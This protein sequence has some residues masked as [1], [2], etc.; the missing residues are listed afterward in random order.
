MNANQQRRVVVT[1]LGVVSPMGND[2]ETCWQ[3]ILAGKSG[4]KLIDT[5]DVT[6]F[7]AKIAGLVR[8]FEPQLYGISPKDARKMDIFVQYGIA[9][10]V[11]AV[12]DA[13][14]SAHPDNAARIGVSIG[15]GIGGLA[16][17]EK[18]HD[19]YRDSGPR[20]ISPF[21][22]PGAI[23]NMSAGYFSIM[24]GYKGPNLAFATACTTGAHS[25]GMAAR[26]IAYGDADIMIAGG[27]EKAS[28]PLGLGGFASARALSTRNEAP[29]Q[30]S[31]PWDV[32]RDGF[33]LGDGASVLV[34]E[35]Y[36]CAKK[37]GAKIYA[38]LVGF[39]MS[40][41][42]FHITSYSE[43]GLGE[44]AA[45][46]AALSDARLAPEAIDY[47]NAHGTSTPVG[48]AGEC[49]AI[50]VALGNHAK[51]IPVSSTKSMTGH[52]LGAAG[53]IEAM[54]CVLA[55]RDQIVPPTI[56]L[57]QPS[58]DCDLDFVP[59]KAREM[60]INTCIS[61]SFGFGGTNGALIFQRL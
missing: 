4:I 27:S 60:K 9:A 37:R 43:G 51:N 50:K 48:D 28:T 21:F 56:N 24:Y 35:E 17:I 53:A 10:A 1:G 44:A 16:F 15:S 46:T 29:E 25:I 18:N 2:V 47:V 52:L 20:R 31:R 59:N 22:I 3:N 8:D 61:N 6:N 7:S 5:F 33:V 11:Q 49:L 42:A 45:M 32:E 26:C 12:K 30:A 57:V 38:E 19:E 14:L 54:F 13:G 23:I 39:G 58:E 55:L 34:L 40:A 41:S 36:E